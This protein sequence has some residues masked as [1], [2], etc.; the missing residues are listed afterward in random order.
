MPIKTVQFRYGFHPY[1]KNDCVVLR[2]LDKDA[3]HMEIAFPFHEDTQNFM[4]TVSEAMDL[5]DAIDQL[6]DIKLLEKPRE[7]I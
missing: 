2:I 4:F 7:E 1:M 6:I 3:Q 5:R